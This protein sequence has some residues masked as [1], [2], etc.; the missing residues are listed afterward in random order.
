MVALKTF[1][2]L[3]QERQKQIISVCLEEFAVHEYQTA[4]LSTI[5]SNLKLAKG[6][7]YRYF[8]NKN[9][10][11]YFLFDYCLECRIK[12]DRFFLVEQATDFFEILEQHFFAKLNFDK[13][14]PLESAFLFNVLQER[15]SEELGDIQFKTKSKY[16]ALIK[17]LVSEQV[18]KKKIRS[19]IDRDLIAFLIYQSGIVINEF[20]SHKY[21]VDFMENIK[22]RKQLYDLPEKDLKVVVKQ[23]IKILKN[24]IAVRMIN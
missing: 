9:T 11:Y 7:F 1:N 19:D 14:Y 23:I 12:N 22:I 18:K 24:G 6:S 3:T 2:N 4:S 21:Q 16:L 13:D 5:V 20:I 10:L 8:E 17:E 15:N